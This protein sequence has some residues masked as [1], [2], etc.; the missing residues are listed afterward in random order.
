[1]LVPRGRA[2]GANVAHADYPFFERLHS[3]RGLALASRV[4]DLKI[5]VDAHAKRVEV[6]SAALSPRQL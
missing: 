1:V 6:G 5:D 4:D 3:L 2:A